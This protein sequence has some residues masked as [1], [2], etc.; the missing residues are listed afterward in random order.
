MLFSRNFASERRAT[1]VMFNQQVVA[2]FNRKQLELLQMF[3]EIRSQTHRTRTL[4]RTS[5]LT[6]LS[7]QRDPLPRNNEIRCLPTWEVFVV[8]R[9]ALSHHASGV[10]ECVAGGHGKIVCTPTLMTRRRYSKQCRRTGFR[11]QWLIWSI[12]PPTSPNIKWNHAHFLTFQ[13]ES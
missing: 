13:R 2:Y 6:S 11:A 5:T 3:W 12:V 10:L 1:H 4:T 7:Q 8:Q 9:F